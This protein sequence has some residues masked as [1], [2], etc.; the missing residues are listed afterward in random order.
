M[1][2]LTLVSKDEIEYPITRK[3]AGLC[4][5]L[6]DLMEDLPESETSMP[7]PLALVDSHILKHIVDWCEHHVREDTFEGFTPS[8]A[9]DIPAWD[10][11]FLTFELNEDLF[12]I[13]LAANYMNIP[14]LLEC[15]I[16]TIAKNITGKTTEEI[17]E[18]L[19]LENDFTPEEL[20]QIKKENE[21]AY[22]GNLRDSN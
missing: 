6:V 19:H 21:W 4:Q 2:T 18:Y 15:C 3:A 22:A 14:L 8:N 1:A 16:K 20:E 5:L 12:K 9:R 17:R 13:T 11:E 10:A 7:I